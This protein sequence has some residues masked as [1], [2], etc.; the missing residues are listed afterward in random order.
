MDAP[1]FPIYVPHA[2]LVGCSV[3][4]F[5]VRAVYSQL[6]KGD[7]F[8]MNNQPF[9]EAAQGL[10]KLSWQMLTAVKY[11]GTEIPIASII[12]GAFCVIISLRFVSWALTK[13]MHLGSL[14]RDSNSLLRSRKEK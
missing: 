14:S 2:A 11:P 10:L 7:V 1:R 8:T 13:R 9:L 3:F 5:A 4:C 6:Y 12:I